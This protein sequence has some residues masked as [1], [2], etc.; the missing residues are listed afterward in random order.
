MEGSQISDVLVERK[1]E[2]Q[3]EEKLLLK[4]R[5]PAFFYDDVMRVK[6]E[7]K[8]SAGRRQH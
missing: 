5:C 3:K 2:G 4:L 8:E 7:D 6:K 1:K